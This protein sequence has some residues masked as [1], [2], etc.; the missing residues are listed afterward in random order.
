[1]ENKE[2]KQILEK[3]IENDEVKDITLNESNELIFRDLD[4]KLHLAEPITKFKKE[5]IENFLKECQS[6]FE[7]DAS[8]KIFQT[9]FQKM[10]FFS[11][12]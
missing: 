1:M 10:Y 2:I 7:I 11:V 5:E 4:G 12:F 6:Q 9:F 3:L 8:K